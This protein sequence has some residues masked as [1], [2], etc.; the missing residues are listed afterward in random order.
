MPFH[1]LDY[2]LLS[3]P[4]DPI[5]LWSWRHHGRCCGDRGLTRNIHW[6][7][8]EIE[9]GTLRSRVERCTTRSSVLTP[10]ASTNLIPPLCPI[11][12]NSAGVLTDQ[13]PSLFEALTLGILG[14]C[15]NFF[16]LVLVRLNAVKTTPFPWVS[17]V[18]L[19]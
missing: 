12:S 18:F 2:A 17:D 15:T 8:P 13:S 19:T 10:V 4:P 14:T 7:S 3:S 9:P 1:G 5:V 16:R 11:V 6:S